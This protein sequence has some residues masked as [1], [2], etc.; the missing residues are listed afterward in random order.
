MLSN[1]A[2]SF[3]YLLKYAPEWLSLGLEELWLQYGNWETKRMIPIHQIVQAIGVPFSKIVVRAHILSGFDYVSKFGTKK[4]ALSFAPLE[5]LSSFGDSES[6][7]ECDLKKAEEYLVKVWV[8]LRRK[9]KAKNFDELRLEMYSSPTYGGLHTLGPTRFP[10]KYM[11][12]YS[13]D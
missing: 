11:H 5:Y 8:G 10:I 13:F 1:D 3:A 7:S 6:L 2:D 9:T 4:T 12:I